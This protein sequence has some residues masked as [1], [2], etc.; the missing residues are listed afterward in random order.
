L[1]TDDNGDIITYEEYHPFGTTSYQATNSTI[2]AS[3]KRYRYTGMER[4]DETGLSYH[5]ARYYIPW[6]GRWLNPDPIGIGDGVNP[7]AYC[8]NN[9]VGNTD[10]EGT[11]TGSIKKEFN[12]NQKDKTNVF[13][14][15]PSNINELSSK[16][17][18]KP[19]YKELFARQWSKPEVRLMIQGLSTV[20]NKLYGEPFRP[21]E[22]LKLT[23]AQK[24]ITFK[25]SSNKTLGILMSEFV[26]GHGKETRRFGPDTSISKDIKNS[27][28]TSLFLQHFSKNFAE[29]K[30]KE[31]ESYFVRIFTSPDNADKNPK[32]LPGEKEIAAKAL[33]Q[34]LNNLSAFYMG[35]IDYSFSFQDGVLKVEAQN[36][37]TIASGVTRNDA[38]NLKREEG[39]ISPL[40]NTYQIF[41]FSF[42]I[43]QMI[44]K[45]GGQ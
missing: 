33:G 10:T 43:S 45:E 13:L 11:Q 32:G 30:F 16:I 38:D 22:V 27:F 17:G 8:H 2:T 20:G 29:G 37:Y 15:A 18:Q 36:E 21:M 28:T 4:D 41:E 1:E 7:Y 26:E 34:G 19:T 35:S 12:V 40:G 25:E 44:K 6:L 5:N 3:A 42:D 31:G 39:K 14:N 24:Q 9:P 23:E